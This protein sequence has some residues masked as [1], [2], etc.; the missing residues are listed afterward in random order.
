MRCSN[1]GIASP[2]QSA[3]LVAAV[4]ELGSLSRCRWFPIDHG[5]QCSTG[6]DSDR[7]QVT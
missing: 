1:G 6:S 7:T 5:N 2:I 3:P 4:A